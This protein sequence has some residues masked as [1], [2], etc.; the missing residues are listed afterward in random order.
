MNYFPFFLFLMVFSVY[1]A[2]MQQTPEIPIEVTILPIDVQCNIWMEVNSVKTTVITLDTVSLQDIQQA[3]ATAKP[4]T[5]H[6]VC[7]NKTEGTPFH[8]RWATTGE[9]DS[10]TQALKN[11][12]VSGANNVGFVVNDQSTS[13][14]SVVNFESGSSKGYSIKSAGLIAGNHDCY[15]LVEYS[16]C[17]NWATEYSVGYITYGPP[18]AGIVTADATVTINFD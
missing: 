11:T 5:V 12:T 15:D 13:P 16:G 1:S 3:T 14:A 17:Y 18:G 7:T 2:E 4:F 6:I 8:T 9:V 10:A